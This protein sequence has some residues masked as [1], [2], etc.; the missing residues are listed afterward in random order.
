MEEQRT[1]EALTVD[2]KEAHKIVGSGHRYLDVR[3]PE[4]YETGHVEGAINIT[5]YSSVTPA[6]KVKNP[7]FI[8]Q[9]SALFGKDEQFIVACNTGVRSKL[10]TLDLFNAGYKNVKNMAGGYVAWKKAESE[11]TEV[12][13]N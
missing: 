2:A 13:P 5:F 3:L 1:T 6:G 11:E 10:A 9:V 12:K 4:V 7:Q 8:E